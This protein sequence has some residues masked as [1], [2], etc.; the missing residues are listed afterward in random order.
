MDT[1][2][3]LTSAPIS[4]LL[5]TVGLLGLLM[6]M[7]T[8][9]GVAGL[10]GVVALVIF[11][12][13]HIVVGDA[14]AYVIVLAVIGLLMILYELHVV[15]GH[16]FPGVIGAVLLLASMVLAFGA[17]IGG[18]IVFIAMQTVATA[19]VATVILYYFGTRL[20]PENA[21][22]KKLTF[23]G[24][25]G[26]DYVASSDYTSLRGMHGTALSFLR[27]AGVA[28]IGPARVDV[29]TQGEF[30][31]AGAPVRVTRVEGARVFV[32]PLQLPGDKE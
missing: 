12:A 2:H 19:I 1:I 27:P 8:L 15:P 10:I 3:Q 7:Q 21:W 30:I 11:F 18:A 31:P 29:L 23:S 17:P 26:A 14:N 16:T 24:V 6:E 5:L 22:M 4:G 9:H 32:E 20:F 13:A 28:Q 25:Q